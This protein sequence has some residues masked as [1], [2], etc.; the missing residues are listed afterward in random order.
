MWSCPC[1]PSRT[2]SAGTRQAVREPHLHPVPGRIA[3]CIQPETPCPHPSTPPR[4][5][6]TPL[7][8][9]TPLLRRPQIV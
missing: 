8:A 4:H 6:A 2:V 5:P 3:S 1:A 9:V 7:R